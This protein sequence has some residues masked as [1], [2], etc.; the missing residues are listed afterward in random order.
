MHF[1]W[2]ALHSAQTLYNTIQSYH[3]G[4]SIL[5]VFLRD[6]DNCFWFKGFSLWLSYH[7][8]YVVMDKLYQFFKAVTCQ[9]KCCLF[10]LK[11]ENILIFM[12]QN[13]RWI[14]ICEVPSH[15]IST[16]LFINVMY[17][18]SELYCRVVLKG[19]WNFNMLNVCEMQVCSVLSLQFLL[20]LFF[21]GWKHKWTVICMQ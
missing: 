1:S 2:I 14:D 7:Y 3:C 12:S 19:A 20:P 18:I 11:K 9:C 16:D 8:M 17:K 21:I 10:F 5:S 13:L 4:L 6:K 15:H